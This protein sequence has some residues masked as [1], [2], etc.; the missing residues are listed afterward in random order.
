MVLNTIVWESVIKYDNVLNGKNGR[1]LEDGG[2]GNLEGKKGG[3]Y[4]RTILN[5]G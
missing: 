1:K 4:T 5:E 2:S 3:H